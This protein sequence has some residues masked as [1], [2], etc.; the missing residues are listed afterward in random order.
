[1]GVQ[2]YGPSGEACGLWE[3]AECFEAVD[4]R[5]DGVSGP[6]FCAWGVEACGSVVGYPR[7]YR[8]LIPVLGAPDL[9]EVYRE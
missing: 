3:E 6:G 4:K 8:C 1:M 2:Y 9:A 5:A 7:F